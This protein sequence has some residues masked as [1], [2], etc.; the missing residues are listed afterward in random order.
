MI[1]KYV[2]DTVHQIL[3]ENPSEVGIALIADFVTLE[4]L[5]P[6]ENLQSRSCES[7]KHFYLETGKQPDG[8][9]WERVECEIG[10]I[11]QCME[12]DYTKLSCDEWEKKDEIT[13]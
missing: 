13:T 8:L 12:A 10:V 9:H 11:S 3:L 5:I 7:C 6:L 2:K 4:L 1:R